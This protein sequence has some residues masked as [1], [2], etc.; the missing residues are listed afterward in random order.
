MNGVIGLTGLLLTTELDERQR[1]YAE[2][3]RGAGRG[4][5]RDHQRHPRLLEDRGR[6]A[7]ARDDRLRPGPGRRG[8]R[9]AG[10]RAGPAQGPRAAR[11][12][13]PRAARSGSAATRPGCA[14]CCSTSASN[15]VKF[16]D[17]RRGRHPRP[18]RGPHRRRRGGPL[19]GDRHRHR[20][21]P[22]PTSDRLFDAVLPGR[23]LHHPPVRRHRPRPGDLP[24]ARHRHGRR[25]RRRQRARRRAARSGSRCRS[26][27]P[28]T[29]RPH[30][31]PARPARRAAGAGRRRQRDQPADPQRAA[32][33]LG[34]GCRRGRRTARPHW[35]AARRGRATGG[36]TPWSCSTSACRTWT[37]SSSPAGSPPTRTSPARRLVLLTS[38]PTSATPRRRAAGIARPADQAGPP[39]PAAH[40]PSQDVVAAGGRAAR[41]PPTPRPRRHPAA[42][43]R[44]RRR[45]QR[46]ST[47]WSP[48]GILEHLGY[49]AE[50]ADNG[51]RGARRAGAAPRSTRC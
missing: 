19:R 21:R 30:A 43:A 17:E 14:R 32:R 2:G 9:R 49:T 1:Q 40:A 24:P 29:R 38:G 4:P 33:R 35:R 34:H 50:V 46:R 23:L 20:H 36:R 44:P 41:A 13:L 47:S 51:Q 18:A 45:G 39:V 11:L 22:A 25:D 42:R 31:A 15:A 3:V 8:G 5:A 12:L 27:W 6:Q 16:T 7:R 48:S 26:R 37:G 10:R 28:A